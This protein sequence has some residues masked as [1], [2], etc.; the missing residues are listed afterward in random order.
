M[1][2]GNCYVLMLPSIFAAH[3][4]DSLLHENDKAKI[5][6]H[7]TG[8][9]SCTHTHTQMHAHVAKYGGGGGGQMQTVQ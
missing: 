1:L 7:I 3:F 9:L 2:A 6:T 4:L 5:W 8:V